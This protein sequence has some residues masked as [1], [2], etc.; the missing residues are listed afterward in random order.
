MGHSEL[1]GIIVA[2]IGGAAIGVERQQSG[3]ASGRHARFG[4]IRTFTLLG[5]L[6]G[7]AGLLTTLQLVGLGIVLAAG[8]V[9]L[10]ISGYIAASHQEVDATTEAAALVVVGAGLAAGLGRLA[11]ASG[12][13]AV[14]AL[15]L[16]EKSRIH[17]LVR[18][19]DDQELR[20]A[21]R[22]AVMAVVILPLLPEGPFG[23]LGGIKP[24]ELWL[25][26]LFFSGLSFFGYLARRLLGAQQGYPAAGLLGGLISST[27]VTY[28]FARLSRREGAL[29]QPLA[30]GA[31]AACTMLF[32]RVLVAASVL[33]LAVARAVLP[34]VIAPFGIGVITVTLWWKRAESTDHASAKPPSN[35]LQVGP[36]LEMAG[37]FQMVLFAASAVQRYVGDSGLLLTGAVVGLTDV[38]AL[39]MSMAKVAA[40]PDQAVIAAQAIA[41]GMLAN[42]LLKV[43]LAAALG[44]PQFRRLTAVFVGAMALAIVVSIGIVR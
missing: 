1:L 38:D 3:H 36:A 2:A 11:L 39:T 13:V 29:S 23:P 30:L 37:L 33:N 26:V 24:R 27:N 8:A 40:S 32:P 42:S 18:R 19:I 25:L 12:I 41:I 31:I 35:P 14:S 20:A 34:Y 16:A 28:T 44:T 10:V 15:L 9:A 43:G 21:S 6:A 17:A 4:G 22:F 7:L 5:G